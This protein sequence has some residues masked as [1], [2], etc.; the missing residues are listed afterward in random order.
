METGTSQVVTG[1]Q[2]VE[3]AKKNLEEIVM[4]SQAIDEL[5]QS[6]SETTVSQTR[7][8]T[9]VNTLMKD[10]AKVSEGMSDKSRHISESLEETV[11]VAQKLQASV[12]TFTVTEDS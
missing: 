1:T 4:V 8:S 3:E 12:D 6:I 9:T 11:A 2:L 7:T 10:I 5:V